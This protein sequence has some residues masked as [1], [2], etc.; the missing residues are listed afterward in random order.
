MDTGND[1]FVPIASSHQQ[2]A[3]EKVGQFRHAAST[4]HSYAEPVADD[5]DAREVHE[6]VGEVREDVLEAFVPGMPINPT[7]IT[8]Y[9][10]HVVALIW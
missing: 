4:R 5:H 8:G 10:T 9:P 1:Y 2:R 6:H 7:L 3:V